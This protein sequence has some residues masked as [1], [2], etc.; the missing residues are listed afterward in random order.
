MGPHST[1]VCL[2]SNK[3]RP[4]PGTTKKGKALGKLTWNL[5]YT[6]TME[7]PSPDKNTSEF[8]GV[9]K[10][11]SITLALEDYEDVFSDFDPRPYAVRSLS[12]DFLYELQRAALNKEETG[13]V[14]SLLMPK[15]ERN[16]G[17]EKVILERLR[18]H[19][20][21]HCRKLEEK[22]RSDIQMG[23]WMV[24]LGVA[25]LFAAT[26]ILY[27]FKQTLW[28]AFIVVLLEPA[29]WFT[30]WEGSSL[31]LFKKKEI[32]P[33][34]VFYRKLS[35]AKITFANEPSAPAPGAAK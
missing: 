6:W 28:T 7:A 30:F 10:A 16:A 23:A 31:I 4:S 34:L 12:E 3:I 13:L 22:R 32:A 11:S 29:G 5:A 8:P 14:V 26:Y 18:D 21:R 9:A 2:R 1:P 24:A 27:E 17:R 25:F 20:R 15:D 19:F 35:G 33:E